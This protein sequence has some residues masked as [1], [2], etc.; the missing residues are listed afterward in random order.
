MAV[1]AEEYLWRSVI[2]QAMDDLFTSDYKLQREVVCWFFK[3]NDDFSTVCEFAKM[4]PQYV[5][6]KALGRIINYN[7]R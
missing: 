6:K 1:S 7:E 2:T 3:N 4:S 5:R